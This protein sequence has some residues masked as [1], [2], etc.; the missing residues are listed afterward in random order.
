[1][2]KWS[3]EAI[4]KF[5]AGV[6]L[7]FGM[8]LRTQGYVIITLVLID[9]IFESLL[10]CGMYYLFGLET[11]H[12]YALTLSS[13]VHDFCLW[14]YTIWLLFGFYGSVLMVW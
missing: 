12:C 1:M 11:L 8:L 9:L 5:E 13:F 7:A 14:R 2:G 4:C 10:D 6:H 3:F